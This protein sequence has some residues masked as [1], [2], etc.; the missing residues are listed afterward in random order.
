MRPQSKPALFLFRLK[1]DKM[2]TLTKSLFVCIG[3]FVL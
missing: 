1:G 2:K 3:E